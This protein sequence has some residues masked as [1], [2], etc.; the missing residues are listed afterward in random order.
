MKVKLDKNCL[1][2][3]REIEDQ[4]YRMKPKKFLDAVM[5]VGLAGEDI[6]AGN[7]V[8][9][10]PNGKLYKCIKPKRRKSNAKT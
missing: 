1:K 5:S 10:M 7:M 3:I 4:I 6:K 8:K 2:R 9:L